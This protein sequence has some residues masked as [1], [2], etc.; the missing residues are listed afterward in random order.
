MENERIG[1]RWYRRELVR[2]AGVATLGVALA[3]C[4]EIQEFELAANPATL[5]DGDQYAFTET[6]SEERPNEQTVSAGDVQAGV[7]MTSHLARYDGEA[8]VNDV[9]VDVIGR[10]TVPVLGRYTVGLLSTP[11]ARV[12]GRSVNPVTQ[13]SLEHLLSGDAEG[14][15]AMNKNADWFGIPVDAE[16]W[17]AGPAMVHEG[18]TRVLGAERPVVSYAGITSEDRL[19]VLG[20]VRFTTAEDTVVLGVLSGLRCSPSCVS[21]RTESSWFALS[22]SPL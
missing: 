6:N 5:L 10:Y 13:I 17:V 4:S 14:L 1:K 21:T 3:G 16:R 9:A 15:F 18:T 20:A 7:R 12:L 22:P 19:V 11:T 2:T 8:A